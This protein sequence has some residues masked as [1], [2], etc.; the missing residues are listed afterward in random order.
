[1]ADKKTQTKPVE[2]SKTTTAK[3]T[4]AT[5]PAAEKPKTTKTAATKPATA[6]KP[7]SK[8]VETKSAAKTA[9]PAS[10]SAE[11]KTTATA[12]TAAPKTSA[13][14]KPAATSKPAATVK[15]A[16]DGTVKTSLPAKSAS[17]AKPAETKP[18]ASKV[19]AA[20]A[21][22]PE[23]SKTAKS[24]ASAKAKKS[25]SSK[26][27]GAIALS[28]K[29]IK[30]IV[31]SA[32]AILV[33]LCIILGVVLGVNS[34]NKSGRPGADGGLSSI[35][36]AKP[37]N[38]VYNESSGIKPS[39][40]YDNVSLG[41]ETF[42]DEDDIDNI[43]VYDTKYT[44]TTVVGYAG[45]IVGEVARKIPRTIR[46]EGLGV[47]PRYGYTLS[48]V[49]GSDS[50]KVAA[51]NALIYESSYLTATGTANAGGG[52][53]TWMDENGFLYSGTR[54]EPVPTNDVSGKQ[55]RL[56]K[57]TASVGLYMGDVSDDEPGIIK[58]VTMRNRGYNSY[59]VTGVYAPAGEL[60]KI[61]LSGADMNSTGG[62]IIH[63]GQALY[64]GQ[65][66]NIWADKGQMQ[67]IPH[68]LNTMAVSKDTA[69]YDEENDVWTAYV[70]SFIGGPLY[71]RNESATFTARISGGVA[72]RHFILGYTTPEDLEES[73][74]SSVP[75]F[76]LEVWDRGVLH[77]GPATYAKAFN[78]EQLYNA[79]VLWDKVSIVANTNGASQGIVFL[80]DPFV[81]AG[82]AVAF[83]G[84]SS[85]NCPMGWMSS[86]LNYDSI[87]TS[88]SWGNF[89]EF[90]HN[91]QNFGI[92][93]T[94]EVTN[95]ALN[96]VD[97]SLFT[98]ISAARSLGSYGGA[99]LSGWNC[100][101]SATWAI[102][103]VNA[104]D[105][106]STSGLAVYATLLHN[107]GQDAFIKARG[108][109][110]VNYFNRWADVTHYD[111]SYYATAV[112]L[113]AG[114]D[115]S[116][117]SGFAEN[118]YPEFVPVASV[119]QT[120][121]SF[122]SDLGKTD[123][124]TMQPYVI[125]YGEDFTVD[126]NPYDA[127]NGQY[128]SGS[129][130]I[131]NGFNYTI[132][133]VDVSG[134]KNGAKFV[135]TATP[136]IYTFTPGSDAVSGKIRVTISITY[137][138]NKATTYKGH[139]LEDV[140]LILQFEQSHEANKAVLERT[141]YTY[142][143]ENMYADAREAYNSGFAGYATHE[144]KWNHSNPTQNC[145]TDIWFYPDTAANREKY[146]DAPES[147]FAHDNTIE[148]IEGKLY[149]NE[150]GKY[151]VY[152]RGRQ[153]CALYWSLDGNAFTLGAYISDSSTSAGFRPGDSNTYFDIEFD[154]NNVYVNGDLI[155]SDFSGTRWIYI[156][157]VLIVKN[158]S[159]NQASYIGVGLTQWT[160]PLYTTTTDE[161][162]TTHYFNSNGQEV[163]AEEAS[164]VDPIP[165]ANGTYVNAYRNNYE[166][167]D[168]SSY[169]TD[170]F[171]TR[172]YNYNY[173]GA[174]E[175]SSTWDEG[176][177]IINCNKQPWDS[178]TAIDNLLLEGQDTFF[179]SGR[180]DTYSSGPM[181]LEL[182]MGKEVSA[183]SVTFF[184]RTTNPATT[185]QQGLPKEFSIAI[186]DDG[187]TYTDIGSYTNPT[188]A[189][190]SA[191]VNLDGTYN[192]R[193]VKITVNSTHS[194]SGHFIL[195]GI[196]FTYTFR[197]TGNGANNVS[198]DKAAYSNGFKC[199][200]TYSVYG[201]AYLG[202]AGDTVS[203]QFEGTRFAVLNTAAYGKDYEVWIDGV[204]VESIDV[205]PLT[206]AFGICYISERL[207]NTTHTV[208]IRCTGEACFDSF[209][210]YVD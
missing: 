115:Y 44:S 208:E 86:S 33:A 107:F 113:C 116:Q 55:R 53:Y 207:E 112:T 46:D 38:G 94:G 59:G 109:S 138:D 79:A 127:P 50:D 98:R 194:N 88:G 126:L 64:N 176:V 31:I 92:G 131:G 160:V 32:A 8:S 181:I 191:T 179:H 68:L 148:V 193:Y 101:T 163:T 41:E 202:S 24:A 82:A 5:K 161:D 90:H 58:D 81:A 93:Y 188:G 184:G 128:A 89:H 154:E 18:A 73:T 190:Y 169:K 95:N 65:A 170:Y 180:N 136:G 76:D 27:G 201:H 182:D 99:G 175:I 72:Y 91:F 97:Y 87:V 132:K 153:N 185:S 197:L 71:I 166:F 144:D 177:S 70:G 75:Y 178:T 47:Y 130:V 26:S 13:T 2:K 108:A 143:E 111:F 171:Y 10:K 83:P 16:P 69:V 39:A 129:V 174:P 52:K 121:R 173:A 156:K 66:N 192:F 142:T 60:I 172:G 206:G 117:N 40:P 119:Y 196:N 78:Y 84:R 17:A 85:V 157:E 186:S 19:A 162:G 96:L 43:Y 30:I 198:P 195:S 110:G 205:I 35:T 1:M 122:T 34:C 159:A 124:Q 149:I 145:N 100:Y 133:S 25:A 29:Q 146:P 63:I 22:K 187:E 125:P 14:A 56:Y 74:A 104:N 57:H 120:G 140:D 204:K 4:A 137:G 12:K 28:K 23:K 210:Y 49:I 164:N 134:L 141:T 6:A 209:A 158:L 54:A 139:A 103:R 48:T 42:Y 165:P 102:G 151:R 61:Q 67:R 9:K 150:D 135:E 183:N 62:I 105:I 203:L 114:E 45:R 200:Q 21:A 15:P 106:N 118:N 152:L 189:A 37:A 123:I 167:A 11:T 7:A 51:R 168:N 199:I 3:T 155:K 20:T 147:Y 77:S 80:Y 36:I